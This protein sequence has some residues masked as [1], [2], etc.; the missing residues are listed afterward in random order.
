MVA[1]MRNCSS[2]SLEQRPN[3]SWDMRNDPC[4]EGKGSQKEYAESF[5]LWKTFHDS[6]Q[7]SNTLD[8]PKSLQGIV[9]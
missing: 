4:A 8:I 3:F 2:L 1:C 6:L 5:A 7:N 9:L